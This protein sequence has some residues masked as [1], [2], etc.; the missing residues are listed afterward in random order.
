MAVLAAGNPNE[1][2]AITRTFGKSRDEIETRV[3]FD[4]V[5]TKSLGHTGPVSG[6][7]ALIKAVFVLKHTVIPPSLNFEIV[8]PNLRV[9][10]VAMAWPQ[11]RPLRVSV[12]NFDD[13]RTNG[14]I[15]LDLP[16]TN[17]DPSVSIDSVSHINGHSNDT[18]NTS[19]RSLVYLLSAKDSTTCTTMMRRFAHHIVKS[20]SKPED[21]AYTLAERRSRHSWVA[22]V[23]AGKIDELAACLLSPTQKPSNTP[24]EL[25]ELG[26]VFNGPYAQ[27]HAMGRELIEAYP[28]FGQRI[29]EA[30]D[31]LKEYG[32]LWS[33]KEELM[34]DKIT[35]RVAEI[36]L[37]Q[38][39]S[40]AIQ[41]CLADLLES[42]GIL[43]TAV[44]SHSSGEI[45]AAYAVKI[46]SFKEALGVA[47]FRG[48]LCFQKQKLH[49]LR[50]GMLVAAVS[51]A[52]AE[53]YITSTNTSGGH[54]VVACINSPFHVTYSGDSDFLD[55]VANN[56]KNDDIVVGK[57]KAPMAYHSHHMRHVE[58]EYIE[59]LRPILGAV[60]REQSGCDTTVI[61]P[62]T[63]E[64]VSPSVL[65]RPEHWARNMTSPVLFSQAFNNMVGNIDIVVGIGAHSILATPIRQILR[66]RN[67]ERLYTSYLSRMV[68]AVDTMQD[69]VLLKGGNSHTN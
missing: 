45:A 31:I 59:K 12:G 42:W 24:P 29:R 14:H 35:T 8:S 51:S 10:T 43:P 5:N 11:D 61:S 13:G 47:Y 6:I 58:R 33:L 54:V 30:D 60:T 62:V 23:R 26:F 22:A 37:S 17:R 9:P 64:Q 38:P 66:D 27:W 36:Q 16:L 57:L 65:M 7:A 2:E 25:P 20:R 52:V 40:V 15:I 28:M 48:E 67:I 56:L 21:L 1:A 3:I 34:R 49:S 53:K 44:T 32:A 4:S 68:D 50:G 18:G 19:N 46:L 41:F 55:E 63:G 69:M 39:I